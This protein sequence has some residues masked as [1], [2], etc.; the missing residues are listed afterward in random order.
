MF[1]VTGAKAIE[2]SRRDRNL[3]NLIAVRGTLLNIIKVS[4]GNLEKP[5]M[6]AIRALC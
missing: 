4:G 3:A 2:L 1:S 6:W 5:R